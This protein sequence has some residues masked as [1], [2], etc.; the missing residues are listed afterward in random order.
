MAQTA[1]TNSGIMRC[2]YWATAIGMALGV[3]SLAV[4]ITMQR[5]PLPLKALHFGMG[6]AGFLVGA[7]LGAA[8]YAQLHPAF[9]P[10]MARAIGKLVGAVP[11]LVSLGGVAVALYAQWIMAA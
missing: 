6:V 3:T 10:A 2:G 11:G 8:K 1:N 4:V 7:H 9:E 5:N